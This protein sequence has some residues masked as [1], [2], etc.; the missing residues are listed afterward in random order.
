MCIG[1][2][3]LAR[4]TPYL[5]IGVVS[6]GCVIVLHLLPVGRRMFPK[7]ARAMKLALLAISLVA[8]AAAYLESIPRFKC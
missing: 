2:D 5:I 4:A 3:P 8:L 6:L 7:N 1:D